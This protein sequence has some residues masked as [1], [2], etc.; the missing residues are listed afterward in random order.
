VAR[1]QAFNAWPVAQT[2]C[3]KDDKPQVLRIW[4]A[5]VLDEQSEK[6]PGTVLRSSKTGIDVVAGD[7]VVR[8]LQVQLPG[9]KPMDVRDFVNAHDLSGQVL[10]HG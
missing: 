6:A 5:T 4:R 3:H 8:L 1:I 2:V 10:G 9:G 7:A